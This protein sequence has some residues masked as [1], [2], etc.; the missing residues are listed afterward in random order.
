[1]HSSLWQGWG[2]LTV[3][4]FLSRGGTAILA[5]SQND[6]IITLSVNI[7]DILPLQE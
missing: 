6:G 1:M 2:C 3:R 5:K 4:E 7:V